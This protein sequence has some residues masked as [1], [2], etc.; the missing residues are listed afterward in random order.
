MYSRAAINTS[1]QLTV[2]N[3]FAPYTAQQL[4]EFMCNT[5]HLTATGCIHEQ[6]YARA[7]D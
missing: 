1:Q 2:E 7:A 6:H 5:A 4:D 3:V